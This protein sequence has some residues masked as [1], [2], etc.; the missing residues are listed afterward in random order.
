ME[1]FGIAI[2]ADKQ[3]G[4]KTI[5]FLLGNYPAHIKY[6]VIVDEHS[7][8][9]TLLL[10]AGFER[11]LIF[12][13]KDLYS[14][15]VINKVKRIKID[16]ILLAWWPFIVKKPIF[17][18]PKIGI[19]NFHP[20]LLPYNRGKHYNFWTIVEDTPFGVTI[21]FVDESIDGGDIVFQKSIIKSWED[22]GESLYN[23]AQNA[24]IE[25]FTQNYGKIVKGEYHK[26]KQDEK[27]GSFH[28]GKELEQASEI[29]LEK[30]YSA[31]QLLNLLR[32]RT[33]LPYPSC[34]FFDEGKKYEVRIEIKEVK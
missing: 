33:F 30:D 2:F 26:I 15:D 34:Y 10:D 24:M 28:Y 17:S 18:L 21:H 1:N 25:L 22:T 29:F 20:S 9:P 32:A 13:S 31:K 4:K 23:K 6:L 19:L 12:F 14:E 8:I 11:D 3:V 16:Y 5:E 7:E 27:I